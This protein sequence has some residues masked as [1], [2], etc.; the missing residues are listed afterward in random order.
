M[1]DEHQVSNCG[2]AHVGLDKGPVIFS[3]P[4]QG[5]WALL[6]TAGALISPIFIMS[7]QLFIAEYHLC[8]DVAH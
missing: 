7:F 8:I 5:H 2:G 4:V 1:L 6:G 3:P